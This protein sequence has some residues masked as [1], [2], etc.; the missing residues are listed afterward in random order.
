[1]FKKE[2]A[3]ATI[4]SLALRAFGAVGCLQLAGSHDLAS[5]LLLLL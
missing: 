3:V 5:C 1:M 4:R 2:T